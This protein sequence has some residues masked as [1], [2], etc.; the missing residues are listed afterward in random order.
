MES[1]ADEAGQKVLSEQAGPY[2]WTPTHGRKG[3][4]QVLPVRRE[5][6]DG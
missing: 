1:E 3:R 6:Q 4:H 2:R 5:P